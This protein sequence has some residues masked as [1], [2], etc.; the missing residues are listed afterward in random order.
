MFYFHVSGKSRDKGIGLVNFQFRFY[1]VVM[2]RKGI[3][4]SN[5]YIIRMLVYLSSNEV[6]LWYSFMS[7]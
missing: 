6:T 3:E 4:H 5:N 7:N 1:Y 2:V